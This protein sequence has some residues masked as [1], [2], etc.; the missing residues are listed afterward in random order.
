MKTK[1]TFFLIC[2]FALSTAIFYACSKK[3]DQQ[4]TNSK[5]SLINF[6][7]A[8]TSSELVKLR[9]EK[10][11][12]VIRTLADFDKIITGKQSPLSKLPS[13]VVAD[14]R[15]QIVVR[16]NVGVVGLDYGSIK[17]ALSEDEFAEVMALFGLDTKNGFWGF[18]TNKEVL[19]KLKI[20]SL[21]DGSIKTTA[22]EDYMEYRCESPHTC[23]SANQKICLTGC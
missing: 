6:T 11:N 19:E 15:S 21:R 4:T 7:P 18:S 3:Q 17:K 12:N 1:K 22:F 2:A 8:K 16:D 10:S 9:A 23:T 13:E 20:N 14:F 5:N